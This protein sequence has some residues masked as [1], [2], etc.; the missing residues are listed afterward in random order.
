MKDSHQANPS[1]LLE[2]I[3]YMANEKMVR[4]EALGMVRQREK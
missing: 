4:Y 3:V 1:C 2:K